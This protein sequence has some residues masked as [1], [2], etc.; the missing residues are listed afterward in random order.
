MRRAAMA[1]VAAVLIAFGRTE[2]PGAP[3]TH[4]QARLASTSEDQR[5]DQA[6][7]H[8]ARLAAWR[9]ALA[10]RTRRARERHVAP[11]PEAAP[12]SLQPALRVASGAVD[13]L[14]ARVFGPAL[15]GIAQCIADAESGDRPGAVNRSGA[16]GLFQLMPFWWDGSTAGFPRIDPLDALANAIRAREIEER[17]GWA[18]WAGDRCVG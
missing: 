5:T 2:A 13:R 12:A 1:T 3:A 15:E 17:D 11:A 10:A 6:F 7:E 14:I 18:P 4:P 8:G 16:S 9:R